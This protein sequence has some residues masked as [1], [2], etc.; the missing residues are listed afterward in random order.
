MTNI[1]TAVIMDVFSLS[2]TTILMMRKKWVSDGRLCRPIT[3]ANH[4]IMA[5]QRK[6]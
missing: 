6:K 4:D 5:Q 3:F 1:T 2:I